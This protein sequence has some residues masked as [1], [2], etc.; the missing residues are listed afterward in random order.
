[1]K[2]TTNYD[3]LPRAKMRR[4]KIAFDVDGTLRCNCTETCE[5]S[6]ERIVELFKILATFKN[7]ELYVWSGGGAD[8]AERFADK[9]GL[10]VPPSRCLSKFG[11]PPMDVCVDDI[12]DTALAA[13]NLIVREK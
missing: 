1:M 5:D 4:I 12:Q 11:A 6:N 8:Y 7:V 3:D 9:F 10:N 2:R 13:I